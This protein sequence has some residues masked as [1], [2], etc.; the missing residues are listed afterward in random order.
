MYEVSI[1]L[2]EHVL[3]CFAVFAHAWKG[4]E[5]DGGGTWRLGHRSR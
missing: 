3:C 2:C 5:A 4:H 1:E